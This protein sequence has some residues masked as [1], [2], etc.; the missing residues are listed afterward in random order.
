MPQ[1][2]SNNWLIIN[3]STGERA[4]VPRERI[5]MLLAR[6]D[7]YLAHDGS[8]TAYLVPRKAHANS[9]LREWRK[10]ASY[11]PDTHEVFQVMQ[12]VPLGRAKHT[13]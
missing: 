2:A 4:H 7:I 6:G 11:N 13:R 3:K 8:K 12:L 1:S 5:D 10:T 9:T